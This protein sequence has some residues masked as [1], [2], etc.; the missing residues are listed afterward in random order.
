[1]P[2]AA[3]KRQDKFFRS[4]EAPP[5]QRRPYPK[6]EDECKVCVMCGGDLN[7]ICDKCAEELME[8]KAQ[9]MAEASVMVV[10]SRMASRG[11]LDQILD[12][13]L[14]RRIARGG[15]VNEECNGEI[16]DEV[17]PTERR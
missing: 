4:S 14:A 15:I 8:V 13:A 9:K 2:G 6:V 12:K 11:D 5:Q 3:A 10:L 16:V 7:L 1:M 17:P